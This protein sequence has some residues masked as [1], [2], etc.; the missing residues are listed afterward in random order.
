MTFGVAKKKGKIFILLFCVEVVIIGENMCKKKER[1]KK[2][3][4]EIVNI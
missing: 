4:L 1:K 3:I 2:T